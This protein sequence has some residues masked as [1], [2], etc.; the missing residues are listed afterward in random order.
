MAHAKETMMVSRRAIARHAERLGR[1]VELAACDELFDHP[2]HPYTTALLAAVP[3]P[4]REQETELKT[5]TQ[6]TARSTPSPPKLHRRL[7]STP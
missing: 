2:L 5:N 7:L 4:L 3:V 6:I 1:V